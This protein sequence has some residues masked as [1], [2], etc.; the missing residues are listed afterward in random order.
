M[1]ELDTE[2]IDHV[3]VEHVVHQ[4]IERNLEAFGDASR[5]QTELFKD[6]GFSDI[7][8]ARLNCFHH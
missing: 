7:G 4:M 6:I 1:E 3:G 8:A 5:N 2:Y